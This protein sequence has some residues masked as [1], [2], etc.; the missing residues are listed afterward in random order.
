[1]TD[2]GDSD[3]SIRLRTSDLAWREVSDEIVV[4]EFRSG[5]YLLVNG[6]GRELWPQLVAG[7]TRQR[8][9]A[10][11][12]DRHG[13]DAAEAEADVESFVATLDDFGLLE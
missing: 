10:S 4:L 12:R 8:L 6:T 9:A 1:M 5:S 2:G 11:V 13:V 3:R 7:T